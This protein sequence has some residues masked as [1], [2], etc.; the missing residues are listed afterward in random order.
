MTL[1]LVGPLAEGASF[2]ES[3]RFPLLSLAASVRQVSL[4]LLC[5]LSTARIQT[6]PASL[7]SFS[8]LFYR[9]FSVFS[10]WFESGYCRCCCCLRIM[11]SVVV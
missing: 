6:P 4:F 5:A 8:V 2:L 7:I 1:S 3:S 10:G 9:I 11:S